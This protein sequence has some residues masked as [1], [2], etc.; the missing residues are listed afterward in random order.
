MKKLTKQLFTIG[1]FVIMGL[2]FQTQ[3]QAS[4]LNFKDFKVMEIQ[5][6]LKLVKPMGY[7][8]TSGL[9]WVNP[10]TRRDGTSVRGHYRTSPDG[11]CFNNFSGC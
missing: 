4:V 2:T 7:I 1:T 5:N 10:Y 8:K 11:Y 9:V 3:A 6:K